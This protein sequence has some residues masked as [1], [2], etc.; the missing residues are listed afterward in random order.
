MYLKVGSYEI[1]FFNAD[2]QT[3]FTESDTFTLLIIPT[4]KKINNVCEFQIYSEN[5]KQVNFRSNG[6]TLI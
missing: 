1:V 3:V 5:R 6:N 4:F 2:E